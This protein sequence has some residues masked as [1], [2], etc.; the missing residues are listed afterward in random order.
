[1]CID[2][3]QQG[4]QPA[5][6]EA[7]P[8][9]ALLFGERDIILKEAHNRIGSNPDRYL[10]HVWGEKEYGGTCVLYVSDV[11]LSKLG[12]SEQALAGIP[13][14]T[15]PLI[16][17]TPFIG[18]SVAATLLSVNWIVRRRMRLAS[19]QSN[20]PDDCERQEDI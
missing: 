12:W 13:S 7:C 17:K 14:L 19:E 1:M 11:D 20:Q 15:N 5:C 10:D 8:N 16:A 6:V 2:R 9:N 4:Q 18:V 3:L